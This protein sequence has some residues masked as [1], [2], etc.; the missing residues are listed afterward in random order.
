MRLIL[1]R[2]DRIRTERRGRLR[3]RSFLY[4]DAGW[5]DRAQMTAEEKNA[6]S[7]RGKAMRKMRSLLTDVGIGKLKE[8]PLL[9]IF[10]GRGALKNVLT[11]TLILTA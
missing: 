4:R 1:E 10:T 2:Y 5:K 6:V 7:H 9:Y 3:I 8:L 11:A